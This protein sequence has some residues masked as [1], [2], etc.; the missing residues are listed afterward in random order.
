MW[1]RGLFSTSYA[2]ELWINYNWLRDKENLLL[3][4]LHKIL[5]KKKKLKRRALTIIIV[6]LKKKLIIIVSARM[7]FSHETFPFN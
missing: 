6:H 4:S 7:K 3:K 1:K 2:K 5:L